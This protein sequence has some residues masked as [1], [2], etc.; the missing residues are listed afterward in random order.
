MSEALHARE[1]AI[2]G[3]RRRA[4]RR[5]LREPL[6]LA[7]RD[8]E[9]FAAVVRHRSALGRWFSEHA[10]W[11]LVVDAGAGHARLLKRSGRRDVTRPA[12]VRG[13]PPF[14][15]RRYTL[16]FLALAA[17][18]DGPAQTTLARLAEAVRELSV[19]DP[20]LAPFDPDEHA[21]RSAFVDVL[22]HLDE[23]GVLALRDGDAERYARSREGDAL[24]DVRDRVLGQLLAAPVPPAVAGSP[25]R[26]CE[27]ERAH[28]EEGERIEARQTVFRR[29]LD[30]P[31]VYLDDLPARARDWLE[32]GKGFV[33]ERLERDVGL[34][35]E[36]RR[37]GLAAIDPDG[38][39]TDTLFPDGSSTVKHAA[40][41]LCEWLADEAK[42][43]RAEP[44]VVPLEAI[45]ERLA[46]LRAEYGARW[47]KEYEPGDGG[48]RRLA[49]DALALLAAFGLA[50]ERGGGW[51]A[52]PAAARFAP[53]AIAP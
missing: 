41:L 7:A 53:E 17:L 34:V 31:V 50:A 43:S 42:R 40:L 35:V 6:L 51:A 21:E 13:K 36:R 22:R 52:L 15:R 8:P 14:D 45:L 16:L 39:L 11:S 33:Y 2:A 47:S 26:M 38:E 20:S 24:Y 3:E 49:A 48:T 44:G 18:D 28:T 25:G 1:E 4:L 32:G 19:E 27:E 37:E 10:G 30:D 12:H 5:L 29:L 46:A 9:A 23:L